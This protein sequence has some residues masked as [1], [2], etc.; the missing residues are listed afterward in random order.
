M[1]DFS[2]KYKKTKF[3]V[4]EKNYR[5]TQEILDTS[6]SLIKNNFERLVNKI[7]GLKKDLISVKSSSSLSS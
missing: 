1:L 5:S 3:I 6:S 2:N 7:N 4:L